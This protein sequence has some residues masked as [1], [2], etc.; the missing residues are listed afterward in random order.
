MFMI[1][2]AFVGDLNAHEVAAVEVGLFGSKKRREKRE[3]RLENRLER[4]SDRLE[5]RSSRWSDRKLNRKERRSD[6]RL[7]RVEKRVERRL[8][9][10]KRV[11]VRLSRRLARVTAREKDLDRAKSDRSDGFVYVG[12]LW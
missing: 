10:G 9:K 4:R 8:S 2:G 5:K 3:E 11:P 6:R 12:N 7:A 1:D